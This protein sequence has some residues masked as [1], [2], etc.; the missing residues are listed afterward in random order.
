MAAFVVE[1][2][3]P[4]VPDPLPLRDAAVLML[5]NDQNV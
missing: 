2:R 3:S 4:A 5:L 1:V